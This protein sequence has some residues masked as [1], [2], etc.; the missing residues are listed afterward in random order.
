M[1]AET[2]HD[3]NAAPPEAP[4]GPGPRLLPWLAQ[5]A[6]AVGY[7]VAGAAVIWG[8]ASVHAL[9]DAAGQ[10]LDV[11]PWLRFAVGVVTLVG[12]ITLLDVDAAGVAALALSVAAIVTIAVYVLVLRIDPVVPVALLAA[13]LLVAW[14][15]RDELRSLV[16]RPPVPA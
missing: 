16:T 6:G 14:T 13:T 9:F 2:P 5:I 4:R 1:M 7:A 12:A 11:G 8:T 3:Q 10:A 15:R